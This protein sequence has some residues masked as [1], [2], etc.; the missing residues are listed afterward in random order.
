MTL[1]EAMNRGSQSGSTC[2]R[3]ELLFWLST[4]EAMVYEQ[5]LAR[6][7]GAEEF[8]PLSEGEPDRLLLVPSPYDEMYL[9]YLEAQIHYRNGEFTRYN[10]A[11][12]LFNAIFEAYAA[13]YTRSH[14]PLSAGRFHF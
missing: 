2:T 1:L 10:N 8:R 3:Q 6:H 5:I 4:L 12:S 13:H 9:R 14:M 11:I 7:G